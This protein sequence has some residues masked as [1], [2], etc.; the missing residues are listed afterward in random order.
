MICFIVALSLDGWERNVG[1]RTEGNKGTKR[2]K[3][4]KKGYKR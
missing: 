1:E 4:R 2:I 3:E